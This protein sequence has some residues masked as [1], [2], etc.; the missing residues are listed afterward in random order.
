VTGLLLLALGAAVGAPSRWLLD[1]A[2]SARWPGSFP[3]GT[4]AVNLLGSFILGVVLGTSSH[5]A[6]GPQLTLL[7]GTGFCGAF[8]TFSTFSFESVRL[9]EAGRT[10]YAVANVLLSLLL[11]CLLALGGWSLGTLVSA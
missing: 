10:W 9:A 6:S 5:V 4:L 2:L 1:R 8:T 11:G 7:L 3:W